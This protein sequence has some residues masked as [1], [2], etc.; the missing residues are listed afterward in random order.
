[1]GGGGTGG[2]GVSGGGVN[3]CWTNK[4]KKN[5]GRP[6]KLEKSGKGEQGNSRRVGVV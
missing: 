5:G 6:S 2:G 4:R 1:V 3:V